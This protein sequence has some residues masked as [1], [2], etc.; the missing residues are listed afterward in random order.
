[1]GGDIAI[2]T[3]N[4]PL[5]LF[6][7]IEQY[8]LSNPKIY[9]FTYQGSDFSDMNQLITSTQNSNVGR[10]LVLNTFLYPISPN[11][12]TT[13]DPSL[14]S[15]DSVNP[16]LN[17]TYAAS[18][19]LYLPEAYQ[20]AAVGSLYKTALA[21]DFSKQ[22]LFRSVIPAAGGTQYQTYVLNVTAFMNLAPYLTFGKYAALKKQDT[23]VSFSTYMS[24]F[25]GSFPSVEF[26]PINSMIIR[27]AP[28]ASSSDVDAII[29][30]LSSITKP[31]NVE[32]L[33]F[34][35]SG[36]MS[37]QNTLDWI[38]QIVTIAAMVV[39]FFSLNSSM[40]TNI[41]EQKMEIGVLRALGLQKGAIFRLFVYEAFV[42]VLSASILGVFVSTYF[43]LL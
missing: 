42:L 32:S 18:E 34:K 10:T 30:A 21:L 11:F 26:L 40:F 33:K 6:W 17:P 38:F 15:V 27:V 1:M 37:A 12:L 3:Y 41:T 2:V 39:A 24:M 5:I 23:A 35:L 7:A 4:A 28:S 8:C 43:I 36:I 14:I 16:V 22:F 19:Q 31:E 20:S 29:T 9:G 25:N 13:T